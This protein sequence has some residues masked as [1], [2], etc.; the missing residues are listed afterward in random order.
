MIKQVLLRY[1]YGRPLGQLIVNVLDPRLGC[2]PEGRMPNF[3]FSD[4]GSEI[5]QLFLGLPCVE[6]GRRR[7]EIRMLMQGI[8]DPF[9][10]RGTETE[11]MVCQIAILAVGDTLIGVVIVIF[12]NR[13]VKHL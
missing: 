1:D 7:I 9:L 8:S 2:V 4:A 12:N 6:L 3:L 5:H 11:G 10:F 13:F